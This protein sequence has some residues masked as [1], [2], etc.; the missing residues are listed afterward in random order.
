MVD[1]PLKKMP[2]MGNLTLVFLGSKKF[3]SKSVAVVDEVSLETVTREPYLVVILVSM[4]LSKVR[5]LEPMG[6]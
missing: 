6:I 5:S 4:L 3:W 2:P 1:C